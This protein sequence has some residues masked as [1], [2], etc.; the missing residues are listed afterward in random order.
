MKEEFA[1]LMRFLSENCSDVQQRAELTKT[2]KKIEKEYALSEFKATRFFNEKT[3]LSN[4]LEKVTQDFEKLIL[5][6]KA[7]KERAQNISLSLER[8]L[9]KLQSSITY[10]KRIQNA[11]L[12]DFTTQETFF[13]D[14]F[15]FYKPKDI[16]SGDFY[17]FGE[18]GKKKI[19]C[20]ADCTGHGVAGAFM[21]IVANNH[22]NEII[23][24]CHINEPDEILMHLDV[25]MYRSLHFA[26]KEMIRDGMDTAV[27]CI[28]EKNK[29]LEFAGA[30]IDVLLFRKDSCYEFRG[31][32]FSI[33]GILT[34]KREKIYEKISFEYQEGD[35][36]F[37][38]S[39][40]FKDQFGGHEELMK[41]KKYGSI[42]FKNLLSS[43]SELPCQAQK[44]YLE[45]EFRAWKKGNPQTDDITVVGVR[46]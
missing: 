8:T 32:N 11:I 36:F 34:G 10:A 27:V 35:C 40:G 6:L 39:D 5:D 13:K 25:L 21:T 38:F 46:L 18:E 42:R 12:G 9:S 19:L 3:G 1:L 30:N 2:L 17:W 33:D 23:K 26:V 16:V 24:S 14:S 43:I 29:I 37:I 22:Y 7:E 4:Y 44:A 45:D 28:D 31:K 20:C 15:I 41:A